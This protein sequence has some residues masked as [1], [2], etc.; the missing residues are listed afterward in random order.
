MHLNGFGGDEALQGAL[1]HLH[2]MMRT[3]PR[4][5]IGH[6]RGL[7][8]KFR[9]SYREVLRQLVA[10]R[11][12]RA[13]LA[14]VADNLSAP[15]PRMQTPLLDWSW[16][17]RFPPWATETAVAAAREQILREL[18]TAEPLSPNRG[19]HFDLVAMRVGARGARRYDQ[20]ARRLGVPTSSPFY[21]D[22]VVTAALAV[23][24][25][26]RL[27]PWEYKPLIVEAM[28]GI[29][30]APSLERVV[31]ADWSVAHAKGL[32]DNRGE[33]MAV[34]EDSGLERLG[35]IDSERFRSVCGRPLPPHM[36]PALLDAT[37]GCER[38]LRTLQATV[39]PVERRRH[40]PQ[41]A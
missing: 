11:P 34:A 25:E 37:A 23:R 29:V 19:L 36:H 6:M 2:A 9:W 1:N 14:D 13:W 41:A 32:R 27:N 35:L 8:A 4:V 18:D 28:R 26:H 16:P 31:K 7:R 39:E 38:W 15:I 33:L 24:P 40:E 21:D 12:Y 3:S 10:N 17:P 20:L 5:A 30:P 22:A